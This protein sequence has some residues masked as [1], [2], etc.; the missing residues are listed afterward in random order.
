MAKPTFQANDFTLNGHDTTISFA[1][2]SFTGR[3]RFDY[4]SGQTHLQFSGDAIRSVGAE[5]ATLVTVTIGGEGDGGD[6]TLTLIMPTVT[7]PSQDATAEFDTIAILTALRRLGPA[8]QHYKVLTL[9]GT[10]HLTVF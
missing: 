4:K 6:S 10:A 9:H 7:L 1:T 2:T 8:H 3:A 5:F